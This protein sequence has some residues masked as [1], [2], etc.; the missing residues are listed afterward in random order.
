MCDKNSKSFF[1]DA[2]IDFFKDACA[3]QLEIF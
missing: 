1:S 3:K 2:F